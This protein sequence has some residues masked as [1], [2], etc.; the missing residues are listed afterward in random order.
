MTKSPLRIILCALWLLMGF[1]PM[2]AQEPDSIKNVQDSLLEELMSQ[3]QELKLQRI[4]LQEELERS[5][6]SARMDSM[7]NAQRKHRIDSLRLVTK[8]APLIIGEDTLL[9]LYARK[10]GILPEVRVKDAKEVILSL[11]KRLTF[12]VDSLYTFDGDFSTD[13]MAG[14]ELVLSITDMDA[15]WLGKSRNA[16][17]EE[18]AKVIQVKLNELQDEYGLRQKLYGL[19]WAVLIIFLQYLAIKYTNKLFAHW[20]FRMTRKVLGM[21]KPVT[22]KEY[23]FLDT[24]RL[25]IIII[26]TYNVLRYFCIMLQLFITVPLLFS[27]FP[28]TK[29][30]TFTILGYIWNPF[31]DIIASFV[32]YL[33]NIFKIAVI[34]ICFRYLVSGVK[35]FANEIEQGRLKLNGFYPDW[36]RPTYYILRTLLYSLMFVMIWPLLPNSD[37]EVFQGVSVFIGIIVSLGSTGIIGNLMAGMVMT[38]MRPFRIGDY[39]K[40]GDTVGEVVEKTVLVTRIRTRKNELITIQNSNLLG[41]QTSNYSL[42][43]QNYGLIVH[44][45]VTIGYDVSWQLVRDIM[46]RAAMNTKGIKKNPKPFMMTTSLDDF[47][48]EYEIN[49]YTSDAVGLSRIYSELHQNLLQEFFDAGVEIMSPHIF[50][51]RDGIDV[52]MPPDYIKS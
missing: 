42:A 12:S 16:L 43:A 34:Y 46:E 50:A 37:S 36:A 41:S 29:T 9:T 30:F 14:D 2:A 35:Y 1:M 33:P 24:H 38:Y 39:I 20:K 5:G 11:G 51:R 44:T 17:A 52:Q 47:Y 26:T 28:E 22:L 32:N 8:G 13:I 15:L 4:M 45:K 23:V 7:A 25:G 31:K 10:G 40:V 18:Y 27:I 49:A 19:M 48:V 6:Q 21:L 3:V